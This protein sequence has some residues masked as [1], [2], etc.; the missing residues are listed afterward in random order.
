MLFDQMDEEIFGLREPLIQVHRADQTFH[1]IF[2]DPF[3][4]IPPSIETLS[5]HEH[6]SV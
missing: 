3:V 1:A 4:R 5:A 6:E 2:E